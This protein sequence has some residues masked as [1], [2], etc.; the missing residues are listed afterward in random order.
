MCQDVTQLNTF[1]HICV[2]GWST[3]IERWT[4]LCMYVDAMAYKKQHQCP[5]INGVNQN[6]DWWLNFKYCTVFSIRFFVLLTWQL[7]LWRYDLK[8]GVKGI[9]DD[10][11][12]WK[13][14]TGPLWREAT[15]QRWIPLTE[16]QWPTALMFSLV[17]TNGR[18][19]NPDAGDLRRHRAHY[20]VTAPYM[21]KRDIW[22]QENIT[23]SERCTLSE[24]CGD[25]N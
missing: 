8:L 25:A 21:M 5:G 13:R 7:K 17:W 2:K 12:K 15:G 23:K 3:V 9:H 22:P 20:D 16:G 18:S 4:L 10:V 14:V 1:Y 19:N 24:S 6:D 11:I